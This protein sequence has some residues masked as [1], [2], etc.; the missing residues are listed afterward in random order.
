MRAIA[1]VL[2]GAVSAC[3]PAVRAI[4]AHHPAHADADVGRLAGP[5]AALR[6]SGSQ[7]VAEPP[8]APE[9]PVHEHG[10]HP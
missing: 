9:P 10:S 4:D 3:T 8:K 1:A 7:P 6:S 2:I 5:P